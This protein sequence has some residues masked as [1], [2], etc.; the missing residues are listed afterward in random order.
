MI[1]LVTKIIKASFVGEAIDPLTIDQIVVPL[2]PLGKYVY[3]FLSETV[4]T[5]L[6]GTNR[7]VVR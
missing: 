1:F 7:L 3:L 6:T 5:F 4:R 2:E